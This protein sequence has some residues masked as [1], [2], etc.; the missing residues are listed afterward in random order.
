[1]LS[2]FYEGAFAVDLIVEHPDGVGYLL[3]ERVGDVLRRLRQAG[4]GRRDALDPVSSAACSRAATAAQKLALGPTP[5]EHR[6]VLAILTFVR[7]SC[8]R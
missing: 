3:T 1:M 7:A 5:H 4:R 6:R 8:R 2:Q